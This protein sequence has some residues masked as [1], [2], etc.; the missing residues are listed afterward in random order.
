MEPG[1]EIDLMLLWFAR[2]LPFSPAPGLCAGGA[3]APLPFNTVPA[4]PLKIEPTGGVG[5][6]VCEG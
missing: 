6:S 4:V 1:M 3:T 2:R 5:K